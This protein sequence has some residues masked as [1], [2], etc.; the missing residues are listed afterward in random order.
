M[1]TITLLISALLVIAA[2]AASLATAAAGDNGTQLLSV[3]YTK[4]QDIAPKSFNVQ[5]GRK[6]RMEVN[7][8]DSGSGCM[9]DI[10]VPGLW[11][12]PEA[13]VKGKKVVMEFTPLRPGTY[14]ITC[15]M[16]VPRGVITVR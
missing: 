11:E 13:L 8:V 7:V 4:A 12:R 2:P 15:S 16:G 10:K 5:A 6:V 14:K 3:S 9:K 1:K